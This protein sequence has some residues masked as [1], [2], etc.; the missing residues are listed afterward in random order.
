MHKDLTEKRRQQKLPHNVLV[1]ALSLAT[2][3]RELRCPDAKHRFLQVNEAIAAVI[4]AH[5]HLSQLTESVLANHGKRASTRQKPRRIAPQLW[6]APEIGN[7][8]TSRHSY[9]VMFNERGGL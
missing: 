6:Y 4:D 7:I 2:R 9:R 3:N 1:P 8:G 5:C